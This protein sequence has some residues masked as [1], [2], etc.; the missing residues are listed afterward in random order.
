MA[1]EIT[2][3]LGPANS[4]LSSRSLKVY[5]IDE[6]TGLETL[7]ATYSPAKTDTTD[8]VELSEAGGLYRLELTNVFPDGAAVINA[9]IRARSEQ[10]QMAID[11]GKTE[12]LSVLSWD[13]LSSSSSSSS[14]SSSSSISS[15][16]SSSG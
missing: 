13:E 3:A 15:S 1:Y 4:N 16:S 9:V 6:N 12:P 11:E 8:S 7:D 5:S 10:F 14:P 2:V